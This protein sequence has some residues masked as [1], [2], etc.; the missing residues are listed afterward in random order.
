MYEPR[1]YRSQS[2]SK[3]LASFEVC[4]QH[5]DLWIALDRSCKIK[6]IEKL[7]FNKIKSLRT[8]IDNYFDKHPEIAESFSPIY[9]E[10]YSD[11]PAEINQLLTKCIP[12]NV[13]PLAC[14]AGLFAAEIGTYLQAK[15]QAENIIVENGG[16]LFVNV[17]SETKIKIDAGESPF[18]DKLGLIIPADLGPVGVCCSSG[19]RGHSTSFGCADAAVIV[20]ES[21]PLA[22]AFAT[23]FCNRV[24]SQSD[25]QKLIAEIQEIPEIISAV[26]ILGDQLAAA[27][28]L[29]LTKLA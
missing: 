10:N 1:N 3:K 17:K 23:S 4:Y 19:K 2:N 7:T 29:E 15:T 8:L 24:K 14:I 21:A 13:G 12:A 16:D 25:L 11:A 27:G 5:T 18:A 9:S 20:C 28:K 22:D 26:L 6:N